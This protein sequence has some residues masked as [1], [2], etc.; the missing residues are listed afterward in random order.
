IVPT[1]YAWE[2]DVKP[3]ARLQFVTILLPHSPTRDASPLASGITQLLDQPGLAA[4][5][6]VQG[7]R[8]EL[9]V[10]NPEGTRLELDALAGARIST[11]GWAAYV[12]LIDN[13]LTRALVLQG[14]S[15]KVGTKDV[16]SSADRQDFEIKH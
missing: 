4:V 14:T 3:G 13:K 7:N 10:L 16:S 5:R 6:V 8:C 1:R 15:L 9:A 2:G 12:E 11:D